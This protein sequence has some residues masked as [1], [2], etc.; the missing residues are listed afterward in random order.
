MREE[1]WSLG[2]KYDSAY[3]K[4]YAERARAF[5]HYQRGRLDQARELLQSSLYFFERAGNGAMANITRLDLALLDS[6]R[7][8]ARTALDDARRALDTLR[9]LNC[10]QGL[11]ELGH[12]IFGAVAREA[13][14]LDLAERHLLN[15]AKVSKRKGAKQ[16]LTGAY[17]HLA[18]LYTCRNQ[19]RQADDYLAKALA[20]ASRYSYRVFWD[21]HRPTVLA[22]C[23]RA[24][25]TGIHPGYAEYLLGYWFGNEALEP[26]AALAER[27]QG[28]RRKE[29]RA[30]MARLK[31]EPWPEE[32]GFTGAG[33]GVELP[34]AGIPGIRIRLFGNLEV[35]IDGVAVPEKAWQ[36]RKVKTLFKYL[37]LHKG[38]RVTRE[39]LMELLWP[40]A[41]PDS[42]AVSLRVT[43]SR[44]RRALTPAGVETKGKTPFF[45]DERGTIWFNPNKDYTLDTEEFDQKVKMG[46]MDLESGNEAGARVRLEQA[47]ELYRGDLLEEDLYEDWAAAERERLQLIYLDT[48]QTL[49]RLYTEAGANANHDRAR[50]LLQRALVVNPYREETYLALMELYRSAGQ[51]GEAL[52]LFERC[53][54]VLAEEFGVQPGREMLKLVEE[55]KI[56]G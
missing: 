37:V 35:V 32:T 3:F 8:H 41:E 46:L 47:L 14:E 12:S 49:A 38:R 56:S 16:I 39:Q 13:G 50:G 17:L 21:W 43:L 28:A 15:S 51:T 52:R 19:P 11:E 2:E 44:L 9:A 23:L 45:G 40:E 34:P 31:G 6:H 33:S 26:L 10:G 1:L 36:T 48:L 55:I 22:Q 5:S 27:V 24:L 29:I 42:A 4:A 54:K 7:G 25:E 18:Q 20:L 30:V 53:R